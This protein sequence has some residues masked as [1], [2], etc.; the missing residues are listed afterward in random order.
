ME[1]H[2]PCHGCRLRV[3]EKGKEERSFGVREQDV[4]LFANYAL[5]RSS[6]NVRGVVVEEG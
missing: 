5:R 6:S 1:K 3:E 2:G 4:S